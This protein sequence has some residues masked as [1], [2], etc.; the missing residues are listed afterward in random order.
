MFNI[1][2]FVGIKK[3]V[4]FFLLGS[5]RLKVFFVYVGGGGGEWFWEGGRESVRKVRWRGLGFFTS[6]VVV[7]GVVWS[8]EEAVFCVVLR[9]YFGIFLGVFCWVF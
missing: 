9:R 2:R 4:F 3:M 6:E 5:F 8:G 1:N 7:G